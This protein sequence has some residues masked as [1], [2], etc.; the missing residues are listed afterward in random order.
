MFDERVTWN[1][2]TCGHKHSLDQWVHTAEPKHCHACG[3]LAVVPSNDPTYDWR[4]VSVAASMPEFASPPSVP[5][6]PE[7]DEEDDPQDDDEPEDE[8]D[9]RPVDVPHEIQGNKH[10]PVVKKVAKKAAR[11]EPKDLRREIKSKPKPKRKR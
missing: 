4:L 9:E 3:S 2:K 1:C 7:P 5:A 10:A 6:E 11:A 8:P